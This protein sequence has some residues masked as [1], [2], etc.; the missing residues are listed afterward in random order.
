MH[1]NESLNLWTLINEFVFQIHQLN[2]ELE[3]LKANNDQLEKTVHNLQRKI[4]L[5]NKEIT[6]LNNDLIIVQNE[7]DLAIENCAKNNELL[8]KIVRFRNL[9][10]LLWVFRCSMKNKRVVHII[11]S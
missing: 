7:R 5:C 1:I 2:M 6:D 11:Y 3:S 4:H 9:I 8:K 10:I